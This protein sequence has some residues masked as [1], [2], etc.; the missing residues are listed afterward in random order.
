MDSIIETQRQAHEEIERYEQ[1]L[2]EV[3]LQN[4]TLQRNI[5]RR[6]RKAAEILARI[7]ELRSLLVQQ[8]EDLPG[9]RPKELSLLS[10]PPPGQDDLAEFYRRFEGVKDFHRRNPG[11]N[12]RQFL[13]E[14]DDLVKSDGLQ[15]I[16]VE[17]EEEALTID[18][19]DAVFSG[20]ENYGRYLDLYMAHTQY[21]NLKGAN[22]LSY[23]AFLDMLKHGKVERTLD[24][25]EKSTQAYL[26]YVQTLY[27]YVVS[28][29]ERALPLIDI[30][31]KIKEE[32][33]NFDSAWMA[34]QVAGWA[35]SSSKANAAPKEGGGIWCPF[36]GYLSWPDGC[37]TLTTM[38]RPKELLQTDG[39]RCASQV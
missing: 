37:I 24:V 39:I 9:L 36:C 20:E 2:A 16:H 1:A 30:Q 15:S 4:P 7:V 38:G 6:D 13:N 29:F 25:K 5:A 3:L 18:P 11:I 8:Y 31:T 28:F 32:E 17:D 10:A 19:L 34:G 23:L 27:A 22:R 33:E 26:E 21:L 14:L 12:A 35:E